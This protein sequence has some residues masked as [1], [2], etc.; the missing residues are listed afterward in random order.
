MS[1]DVLAEFYDRFNSEI[2]YKKWAQDISLYLQSKEIEKNAKILDI[3]CGTGKMTIELAKMGY[4][5][6]GVDLS[7]EMLSVAQNAMAEISL[8]P[9][10]VCQDMT[11]LDLAQSYDAALCCLDS[12]NYIRGK[13]SLDGFFAR[14]AEHIRTGGYLFFDVNTEYKFKNIYGN[15]SYIYDEKD[16]YCVWQNFYVPR[17]RM[18]DFDLTFFIKN[19]DGS[20]RRSFE[21]Q[22]EYVYTD[23]ELTELLEKN[24][25]E[26]VILSAKHDFEL[27]EGVRVSDSDERHYFVARRV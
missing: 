22:R 21:T 3:A 2:D 1:Y 19:P 24:G 18:C 14:A 20:Y 12:V 7:E 17:R 23:A 15:N 9:T 8:Y 10:L 11:C 13:D 6:T 16:V 4:S 26:V 27:G 5:L 25:F